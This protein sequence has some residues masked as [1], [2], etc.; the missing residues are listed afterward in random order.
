MK[1]F[2]FFQEGRAELEESL[3]SQH[4]ETVLE[5]LTEQVEHLVKLN[6]LTP[7]FLHRLTT[8]IEKKAD[9]SPRI[10]YKFSSNPLL[11]F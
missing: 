3:A 8:R 2:W 9:G 7:E 1:N 11:T 10:F 6:E 5:K 4:D